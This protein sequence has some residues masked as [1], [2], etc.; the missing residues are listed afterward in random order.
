M[1]VA[2]NMVSR[3]TSRTSEWVRPARR[4]SVCT[5]WVIGLRNGPSTWPPSWQMSHIILS[6]SSTTMKSS[7][8]SFSSARNSSSRCLRSAG[9]SPRSRKVPEIGFI[10]T[11]PP[12]TLTCRSGLAPIRNR[13]PVQKQI[14]PVGAPLGGQ[15]P[16]QHGERLRRAPVVELGPVVATDDQVGALAVADLVADDPLDDGGVVLVA[17]LEAALVLEVH[18]LVGQRLDQLVERDL[19]LGPWRC[20]PRP[21]ECRRRGPRSRAR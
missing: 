6:S 20:R 19:A 4:Y 5:R 14:G 3:R 8:I 21:A 17:G 1:T 15:Q 16:P 13:S 9:S 7:K 12:C 18:R 2:A 11:S 10:R